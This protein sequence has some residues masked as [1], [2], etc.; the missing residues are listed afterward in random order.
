MSRSNLTPVSYLVLGWLAYGPATS[1]DLKRRSANS[2]GYFWE[3]P[4]SQLYAE[5]ARLTKLGLLE[6]K[7]EL[8]GRRR[9]VYSITDTGRQALEDWLREPSSEEPQIRDIGLL[10]LF[11]HDGLEIDSDS[12]VAL[13]QAQEQSHREKLATYEEIERTVPEE[14][15]FGRAALQAGFLFE[16]AFIEFWSGIAANPPR[17]VT[18][19]DRR[20]PGTS[21]TPAARG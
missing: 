15:A 21:R 13:A 18:R 3:F 2:V 10:K 14:A 5:P 4:H 8:T 6:E 20:A 16:R 17:A 7:R 1:Y 19:S 11:F 9:H 12:V